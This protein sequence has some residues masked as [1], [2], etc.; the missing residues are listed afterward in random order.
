MVSPRP[1]SN[2]IIISDTL[3]QIDPRPLQARL[4]FLAKWTAQLREDLFKLGP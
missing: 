2:V 4:A 3:A 1:A